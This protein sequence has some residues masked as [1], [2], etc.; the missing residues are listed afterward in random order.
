[1]SYTITSPINTGIGSSVSSAEVAVTAPLTEYQLPVNRALVD[2]TQIRPAFQLSGTLKVTE[3]YAAAS[4]LFIIS[5]NIIFDRR[6]N[7]SGL[8]TLFDSQGSQTR[9]SNQ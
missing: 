8:L 1:M 2:L 7:E 6:E 5:I 9:R 4:H 3:V